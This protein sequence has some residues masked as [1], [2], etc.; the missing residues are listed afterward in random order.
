MIYDW[1]QYDIYCWGGGGVIMQG[2]MTFIW[3]ELFDKGMH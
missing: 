2:Q 3:L 1:G